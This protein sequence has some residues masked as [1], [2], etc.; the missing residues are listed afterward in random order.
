ME[1]EPDDPGQEDLLRLHEALCDREDPTAPARMAELL[2]PAMR[3]RFQN[4]QLFDRHEV[5]SLIGLSIARYVDRPESYDPARSPLLAYLWRDIEGDRKHAISSATTRARKVPKWAVLELAPTGRNLGVE[6]EVL[7]ALDPF[8]VPEE[9]LQAARSELE[10]FSD[11]DRE[12]LMLLGEGVRETAP[13]AEVLSIAHLP[14]GVQRDEVNR[15]KARLKARL[16]VIRGRLG[17]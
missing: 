7:D 13:Y 11:Q 4:A 16:E 9:L 8:D 14:V 5:D 1:P 15:N 3:R 12:F 17:R 6:E 2:L 10:G